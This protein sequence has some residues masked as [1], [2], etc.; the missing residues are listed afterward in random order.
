[1]Q[2]KA[3]LAN[4]N[5]C[6]RNTL[7]TIPYCWQHIIANYGLQVKPS[8][9]VRGQL[10][11]FATRDFP[12]NVII[13]DHPYGELISE[14]NVTRRY[15]AFDSPFIIPTGT[16]NKVWDDTCSRGLMGY[17]QDHAVNQGAFND[18]DYNTAYASFR[19][20]S[21]NKIVLVTTKAIDEGDEL[22]VNKGFDAAN[23]RHP[24]TLWRANRQLENRFLW[25]DGSGSDD[26]YGSTTYNTR[27]GRNIEPQ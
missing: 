1:M 3:R 26:R 24:R 27:T 2:C 17:V 13:I 20:N 4:G 23:V 6:S 7:K 18:Q 19:G 14:R 21:P 25:A 16:D 5:R 15:G 11:I 12:P 10:G 8:V 22:L 9:R